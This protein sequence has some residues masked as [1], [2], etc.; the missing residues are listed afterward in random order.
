MQTSYMIALKSSYFHT[1]LQLN[2]FFLFPDRR[3]SNGQR[4][5]NSS[6]PGH[7]Q[8]VLARGLPERVEEGQQRD[9]GVDIIVEI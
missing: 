8:S 4:G 3:G 6:V 1:K 9:G 2:A 5:V 7:P